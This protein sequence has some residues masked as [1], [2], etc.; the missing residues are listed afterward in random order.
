MVKSLN[1]HP[2]LVNPHSSEMSSQKK[3]FGR[4]QK[5]SVSQVSLA[6]FLKDLG[7]ESNRIEEHNLNIFAFGKYNQKEAVFKLS[8]TKENSK[9]LQNEYNWNEVVHRVPDQKHPNFTVPQNL[10]CG[11]YK[12]LFYLIAEKFPG[13]LLSENDGINKIHQLARVTF[14]IKNLPIPKDSEFFKAQNNQKLRPTGYSS[15]E[16]AKEWA[17]QIPI[18]L[19]DFLRVLERSKDNLESSPG[20]GGFELKHMFAVGDRIGLIDGELAGTL[21]VR[22]YDAAFFYIRLRNDFTD[23][24]LAQQYLFQFRSLLPREEQKTFWEEIKF[25]LI[26]RYFGDLWGAVKDEKRLAS[27]EIVGRDILKDKILEGDF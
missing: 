18:D 16:A 3:K 21:G 23:S 26:V 12:E 14:E 8:S 6:I 19:G 5:R 10:D 20:H 25:P 27:L 24:R 1:F 4:H 13:S 7:F 22:Y 15:L 11:N 9:R 17:S 2:Q